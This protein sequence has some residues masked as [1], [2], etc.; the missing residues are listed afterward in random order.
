M[1]VSGDLIDPA[2]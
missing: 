1:L 2:G